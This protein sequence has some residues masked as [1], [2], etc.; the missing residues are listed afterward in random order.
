M[1]RHTSITVVEVV[2]F[3]GATLLALISFV[4]LLVGGIVVTGGVS[5]D[6]V[7]VA[8]TG[9]AFAGGFSL[10]ILASV[11]AC[12]AIGIRELHEWPQAADVASAVAGFRSGWHSVVTWV[13]HAWTVRFP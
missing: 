3:C 10:L 8:I 1:N 6:P 5:G 11:T 9:M 13:N 12:L 2:A 4:F 7:S